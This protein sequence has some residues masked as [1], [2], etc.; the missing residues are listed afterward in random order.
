MK[1]KM[2]IFVFKFHL[3]PGDFKFRAIWQH[4]LSF[5]SQFGENC[6]CVVACGSEE[7]RRCCGDWR[8]QRSGVTPGSWCPECPPRSGTWDHYNTRQ[9]GHGSTSMVTLNSGHPNANKNMDP[10]QHL[11]D[12]ICTEVEGMVIGRS[13]SVPNPK[14]QHWSSGIGQKGEILMDFIY[15]NVVQWKCCRFPNLMKIIMP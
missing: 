2:W 7:W 3:F 8:Q 5:W 9:T 11:V 6:R 15:P 4:S 14:N 1:M 10:R 12:K 13:L